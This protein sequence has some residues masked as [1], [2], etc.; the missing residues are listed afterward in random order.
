MKASPKVKEWVRHAI[1]DTGESCFVQKAWAVV[2]C[3][4][5]LEGLG[6]ARDL[7]DGKIDEDEARRRAE[8]GKK[9]RDDFE[10][11]AFALMLR[12]VGSND[13]LKTLHWLLLER[14]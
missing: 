5:L 13:L 11:Y 3:A 12:K 10:A 4:S 1:D 7:A 8:V 9:G 14:R 6:A 2:G